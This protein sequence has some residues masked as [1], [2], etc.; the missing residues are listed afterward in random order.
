MDM[1]ELGFFIFM[2]IVVIVSFISLKTDCNLSLFPYSDI[3][4]F[5]ITI[6]TFAFSR[7]CMFSRLNFVNTALISLA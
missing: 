2:L 4:F 3:Y 1:E 6:K 5:V 7:N